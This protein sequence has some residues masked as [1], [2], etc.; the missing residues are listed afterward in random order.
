MDKSGPLKLNLAPA[1]A[2]IQ[3]KPTAP[4]ASLSG[5]SA[6]NEDDQAAQRKKRPLVPL[7]ADE[8]QETSKKRKVDQDAQVLIDKIPSDKNELFGYKVDWALVESVRRYFCW[9]WWRRIIYRLLLQHHIV[10]SKMRPWVVKKIVE[11]LG[12]EETSLVDYICKKIQE[13]ERPQEILKQLQVVLDEEAE[14]FVVKLWRM[15]IFEMMRA[16]GN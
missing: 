8:S 6:E 11:Y 10:Q 13:R 2:K 12:E 5:F 14:V 7:L 1:A 15:L 16:A 3:R 4:T 9:R